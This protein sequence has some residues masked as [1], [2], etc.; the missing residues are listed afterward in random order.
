MREPESA[1]NSESW[2]TALLVAIADDGVRGFLRRRIEHAGLSPRSIATYTAA[3]ISL[4]AQIPDAIL[5]WAEDRTAARLFLEQTR[6]LTDTPVICLGPPHPDSTVA[7]LLQAGADDFLAAP[8]GPLE[9]T[10]RVEAILRRSNGV[11]HDQVIEVGPLRIDFAR[12]TVGANGAS[13]RLSPFEFKLLF[14]LAQHSGKVLDHDALIE[15]VWGSRHVATVDSLRTVVRR[16][17]ARLALL[18]SYCDR[19]IVCAQGYG[20]YLDETSQAA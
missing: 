2:R 16:L 19:M 18:G 1:G 4:Q 15:R 17:R 6:K 5:V 12:R 8:F 11:Y 20:Y 3:I 14:A 13:L 10:A 9:L 7:E